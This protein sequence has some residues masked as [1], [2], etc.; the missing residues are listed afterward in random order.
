M[1]LPSAPTHQNPVSSRYSATTEAPVRARPGEGSLNTAAREAGPTAA[2]R[3]AGSGQENVPLRY[4]LY[5][6]R[7]F[8]QSAQ[9]RK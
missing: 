2:A 8:N 5:V 9:K 4:R 1:R 7:Y 6:Q 3:V